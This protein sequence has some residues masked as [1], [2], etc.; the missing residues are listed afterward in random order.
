M[1]NVLRIGPYRF[2]FFSKENN[3][4]PH[5]HVVRDKCVAKFWLGETVRAARNDGFALHELNEIRK[6]VV[7][8][9]QIL[10]E[11]WNEHFRQA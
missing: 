8:N 1:P 7:K 11:Q 5:V 4:P 6:I 9:R 10:L 3:E 2:G